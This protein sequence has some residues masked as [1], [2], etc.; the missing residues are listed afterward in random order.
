M[1]LRQPLLNAAQQNILEVQLGC[2]A[3]LTAVSTELEVE[4]NA[5]KVMQESDT[6]D[7]NSSYQ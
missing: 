4:G 6:I 5:G 1:I 7:A 2:N 3:C